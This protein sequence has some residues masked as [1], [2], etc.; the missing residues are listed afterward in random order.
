LNLPGPSPLLDLRSATPNVPFDLTTGCYV[1]RDEV[2]G[3]GD[4]AQRVTHAGLN[5]DRGLIDPDTGNATGP[6]TPRGMIGDN[7]AKAVTGAIAET[8]R[9]WQDFQSDLTARYG[10]ERAKLMICTLTRDDPVDDCRSGEWEGRTIGA[11]AVGF[12]VAVAATI[13]LVIRRRRQRSMVS[14]WPG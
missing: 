3:V 10:E 9:Q 2:P 7:F 11:L 4:C 13:L 14:G 1:P 5:K 6:T 8:R 12:A